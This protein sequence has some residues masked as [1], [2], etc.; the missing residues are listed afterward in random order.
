MSE[1]SQNKFEV[2]SD[3]DSKLLGILLNDTIISPSV[4]PSAKKISVIKPVYGEREPL[5]DSQT[6]G[7]R[8]DNR[9]QIVWYIN[10]HA[11]LQQKNVR[12]RHYFNFT[13]HNFLDHSKPLFSS[14]LTL[15][16]TPQCTP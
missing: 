4:H 9:F 1:E 3:S 7:G 2:R 10:L 14:P 8:M 16:N 13:H 12:S 15:K 6:G 5:Y 11:T